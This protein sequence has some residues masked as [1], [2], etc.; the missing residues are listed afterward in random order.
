MRGC[1][2][3]SNCSILN[4]PSLSD[5]ASQFGRPPAVSTNKTRRPINRNWKHSRRRIFP[6][7]MLQSEQSYNRSWSASGRLVGLSFFGIHMPSNLTTRCLCILKNPAKAH[8]SQKLDP[9]PDKHHNFSQHQALLAPLSYASSTFIYYRSYI[10]V[11]S[12]FCVQI[13]GIQTSPPSNSR[14]IVVPR[15][16][17]TSLSTYQRLAQYPNSVCTFNIS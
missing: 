14:S 12:L 9:R 17:P 6:H 3:I 1:T 15:H 5:L 2:S 8:H 4:Y 11:R 7:T 16:I 13:S 10:S